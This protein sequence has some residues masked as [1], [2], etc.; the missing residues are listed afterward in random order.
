MEAVGFRWFSEHLMMRT[1]VGLF[2]SRQLNAAACRFALVLPL[3]LAVVG[4][5]RADE[6]GA[7]APEK[8]AFTELL[9]LNAG[10]AGGRGNSIPTDPFF[11]KR[12]A[13]TWQAPKAGDSFT[14]SEGNT[15]KW[16]LGK[17][18]DKGAFRNAS[19]AYGEI[20]APKEE[21]MILEASGHSS[22]FVNGEP[23]SGDV[24]GFGTVKIPV[25][26]HAGKNGFLFRG[27]R[28]QLKAQ[29]I[30]PTAPVVF[31]P[32][33]V[34]FPDI[35]S[36]AAKE[37]WAAA[38]VV[39]AT[40]LPQKNLVI[41]A[42][43]ANGE[44]TQTAVPYLAPLTVYKAPFRLKTQGPITTPEIKLDLTVR[45]GS[46]SEAGKATF[47][48][49]VRKPEQTHKETFKSSIDDSVQYFAVTPALPD[50]K[51]SPPGLILTLHGA[52]VEAAGQAPCYSRK[53]GF[54]VVAPTNRRS[55][56][57]DWEDWGRLDALEVLEL[58]QKE[59]AT[60]PRR[61]YLTGHSMGG[62]GTWIVGVTFPDRFA[63]IAPS[64][65]W[66]SLFS[67]GGL[68][69]TEQATGASE[70]LQRG[71]APSDTLSLL[72][73]I[74]PRGVY[75][76][77]GDKDDN[78]PVTQARTMRKELAGFHADFTYYERPGAGHW[79]G[80]ECMDWP[81]LIEFL[82]RHELPK[83]GDVRQ[84][85]FATASPG[86][87][88]W[89]DWAGIEAQIKPL[90]LSKISAT[91]TADKKKLTAKTENVARLG[92][93][94]ANWGGSLPESVT[95]DGRSIDL[96]GVKATP[97]ALLR[98][99]KSGSE[100]KVDLADVSSQKGPERYGPFK[101]AFRNHVVFVYGTKGTPEENAW[102]FAKARFDSE[103]FLY[104]GNGGIRIMPDVEFQP[105]A[106][107]DGNVIV[108]GNATTVSCWNELL[109]IGPVVLE[110]GKLQVGETPLEGD[111]LGMI[112]VRPRAGSKRALVGI[113]GGTSVA[114][115]ATT[116]S[117]PYFSSGVEYPDIVV[118]GR[119]ALTMPRQGIRLAGFFAN[120]WGL[121]G[122]D[123]YQE[124]GK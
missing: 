37:Y 111:D 119:K 49:P 101:D 14:L 91:L 99:D 65:G 121:K 47:N 55:Y 61:T 23:R 44:A 69:R 66:V 3:L 116:T 105:A 10:A 98:L 1:K 71:T 56:G 54:H 87:S 88:A 31:N 123:I 84:I 26:L 68:R 118:I 104:R 17:P 96:A 83:P 21:V 35:M 97:P 42:K 52:G 36:D 48:L 108:Y 39:N 43:L 13:G 89:C 12:L 74:T 114:G 34:T 19:Y 5:L 22:V 72:H 57:F 115:M 28:G 7:K 93:K 112:C 73:N 77:H 63:A 24:Y 11:E 81:P 18:D 110:R 4:P 82:E 85:D 86:V 124:T 15:R 59:F 2:S 80:N 75:I 102:A 45:A 58:S 122:A 25:L 120:D 32:A 16:E 27:G 60:D 117:L 106:D 70:Y 90:V 53:P 100:W 64:A 9:F 38:I 41:E 94:L 33:D 62:H 30:R 78:V 109:G 76:L 20:T 95:V 6:P 113:V 107:P 67:Y 79:W 40:A 51:I 50:P 103:T 8:Y 46:E 92:F 29:L